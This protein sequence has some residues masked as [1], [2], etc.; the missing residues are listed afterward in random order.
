M[1]MQIEGIGSSG[2][3]F[4]LDKLTVFDIFN[5]LFSLFIF[6]MVFY[7]LINLVSGILILLIKNNSKNYE[8]KAKL[9]KGVKWLGISLLI[10]IAVKLIYTL[11]GF[12]VLVFNTSC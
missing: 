5:I 9:I 4:S 12:D 11:F 6:T 3:T 10:Y 1:C 7:S 8:G 2:Y